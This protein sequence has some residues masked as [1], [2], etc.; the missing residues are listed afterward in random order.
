MG[1]VFCL[2][3]EKVLYVPNINRLDHFVS[4]PSASAVFRIDRSL[5]MNMTVGDYDSAIP[6]M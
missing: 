5:E 1:C 4:T 3:Y 2:A 6:N